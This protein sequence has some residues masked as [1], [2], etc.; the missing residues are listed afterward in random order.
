MNMVVNRFYEAVGQLVPAGLRSPYEREISYLKLGV[1][2]TRLVGFIFIFTFLLSVAISLNLFIFFSFPVGFTSPVL[3]AVLLM[4]SYVW[5]SILAENKGNFVERTL[6]DALQLMASNIRSGLTTE[7]AL[8]SAARSDFGVL[9]EELRNAGKRISTGATVED[10]LTDIPTR[11]KSKALSQSMYLIVEGIK[12]GGELGELLVQISSDL[13]EQQALQDDIKA[14]VSLYTIL[15]LFASV[16]GAPLLF[17]ISTFIV[18]ILQAQSFNVNI[19]TAAIST[20]GSRGGIGAALL[21]G[22][23][24]RISSDFVLFFSLVSLGVSSL[25]GS[26]TVGV[27]SGGSEKSGLKYFVPILLTALALFFLSR[28]ILLASFSQLL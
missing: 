17:A 3:Y 4:A 25:F 23:S 1:D 8:F 19:P 28:S 26:M 16:V 5:L 2:P 21:G 11:I 18:Q 9:E 15:I 14:N 12:S 6:P 7:A 24:A 13:R 27:I 22:A 10:A 20:I